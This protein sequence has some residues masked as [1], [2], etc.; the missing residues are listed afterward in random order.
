MRIKWNSQFLAVCA[1]AM[2]SLTPALA[3]D[4]EPGSNPFGAALMQEHSGLGAMG[5]EKLSAISVLPEAPKPAPEGFERSVAWLSAQPVPKQDAE[6]TCLTEALYFEARGETVQGQFAVAE[7]ILNRV[8]H[9]RFPNSICGVI[10]QGTGKKY[11][12]Q[13]TYTCDGREEVIHEKAIHDRLGR[14]A[15]TMIDGAPRDLTF[16]ATHYH[17]TAVAPRWASRFQKTA[18]IGV[19]RFYRMPG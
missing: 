1:V 11:A 12:C 4:S 8:D 7:V 13:F 2:S 18:S 17:T 10:H 19:H 15:R 5:S 16:G 3:S 14:I 9:P 6:W